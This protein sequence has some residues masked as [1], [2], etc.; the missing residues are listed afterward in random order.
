MK[1]IEINDDKEKK[2]ADEEET[3]RKL[4]DLLESD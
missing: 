1:M 2:M 4:T 3:D